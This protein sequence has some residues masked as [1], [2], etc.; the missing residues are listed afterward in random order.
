ME[1]IL[2]R[3]TYLAD[4]VSRVSPQIM[5]ALAFV[6]GGIVVAWLLGR[7]VGKACDRLHIDGSNAGRRLSQMAT[8]VGLHTTPSSALRQLVRWTTIV[9]AAAQAAHILELTAVAEVID[10]VFWIAPIL[11]IVL[12]VLYVG[13]ILSERLAHAAHAALERHGTIPPSLGAGVV[14]A[15]ILVTAVVV[16]LEATGVTVN[17][18]VIILSLSLAG[19]LALIVAG[20]IIGG[21]GLLENILA[22]RYVEEQYIEGQMV[23]FRSGRAQIRSIGLMATVVRTADGIDHTTPNTVFL[24]ESL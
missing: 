10:R 13:A 20:L 17:L 19:V 11:L 24:R 5:G 4:A 2:E 1:V 23:T 16:A 21:R 3:L 6:L 12:A 22:A 14:R 15:A 9:V 7:L 18:P 8:F